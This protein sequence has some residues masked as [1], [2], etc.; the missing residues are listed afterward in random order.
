MRWA[1]VWLKHVLASAEDVAQNAISRLHPAMSLQ[2]MVA[3]HPE[4]HRRLLT[5]TRRVAATQ[6][7]GVEKAPPSVAAATRALCLAAP[8]EVEQKVEAGVEVVVE[9]EV[10]VRVG[11]VVEVEVEVEVEVGMPEAPAVVAA[12]APSVGLLGTA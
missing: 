3:R 11:V 10:V 12:A 1:Q 8:D 7:R 5:R 4:T 9:E 6:V 2:A